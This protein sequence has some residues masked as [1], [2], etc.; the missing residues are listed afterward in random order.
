MA[1]SAQTYETHR[2]YLPIFHF[3]VE[4]VLV[5]NVFVQLYRL[6]RYRT[7]YKVWEVLLAVALVILAFSARRMA[8]RAQDRGIR[9]EERTRLAVLL[10][11]EL[12]GRVGELTSSQLVG[13]R[14]ASDAELPD[15]ARR[16]LD[17]ELTTSTQIKKQVKTWR[18]D[19]HR[20]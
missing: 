11:A 2:Q 4:P 16:C 1:G 10:P 6:N 18:P 3:F 20:V 7:V 14:F 19:L 5:L 15:L 13:L 17:G 12:R 8:L 9:I